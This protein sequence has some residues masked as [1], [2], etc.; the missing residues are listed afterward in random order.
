MLCA[1]LV[2]SRPRALIR[3]LVNLG[4]EFL[5]MLKNVCAQSRNT[6]GC[7]VRDGPIY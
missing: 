2:H 5:A 6:E 7:K 4:L 1:V 3:C